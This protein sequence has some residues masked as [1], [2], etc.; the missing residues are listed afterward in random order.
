MAMVEF[1]AADGSRVI[2][3]EVGPVTDDGV[4]GLS[5]AGAGERVV[6]AM[7][8]TWEQSLDCIRAAA[9][10]AVKQLRAIDPPPEE[11]TV[12]FAVAMNGKVGATIVSAGTEAHLH[13]E[14]AWKASS[15][16]DQA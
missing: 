11:I 6:H 1:P 14:V 2:V 4:P 9:A 13:V 12:R 16:T 10:G 15:L 7:E 5:R 3:H 8:R